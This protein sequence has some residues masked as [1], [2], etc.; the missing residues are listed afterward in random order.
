[1]PGL[2]HELFA[3]TRTAFE[4][5]FPL[6]ESV[7]RLQELTTAYSPAIQG[8][9]AETFVSIHRAD[10]PARRDLRPWFFGRF[11]VEQGRVVLRG[12]FA[13][14]DGAKLFVGV[15]VLA[16]LYAVLSATF[17]A[18]DGEAS[19]WVPLVPLAMLAGGFWLMHLGWNA[20]RGDPAWISELIH[21]SLKLPH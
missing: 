6:A 10:P 19:P 15:F 2:L 14:H 16:C 18:L 11:F 21:R 1:M 7:Q 5:D 13:I 9:V 8:T 17:S 20:T 4:S 3:T 12:H